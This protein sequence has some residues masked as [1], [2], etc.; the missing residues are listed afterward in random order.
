MEKEFLKTKFKKIFLYF[1]ISFA[2]LFSLRL[3]YGYVEYSDDAVRQTPGQSFNTQNGF[4]LIRKNY[5]SEK[6]FYKTENQSLTL[7]AQT[8]SFDQKY[9]KVG[10]LASSTNEFEKEEKN[11]REL[12]KNFKALIQYEESSG[13][14][15]KRHLNL[16]IGVNPDKFDEMILEIKKIGRLESIQV[17]KTDKTNE[18]SDLN[19]QR[20]SLEKTRTAL[21][22]FKGKG[23]KI[24]ELINLENKILE[25]EE[26]IQKLGVK[27]GE[28]DTENE[29]CTIKFSLSES[30]QAKK[31]WLTIFLHRFKVALEWTI[32]YYLLLMV[33][34]VFAAMGIFLFILILE[35][36]KIFPDLLKKYLE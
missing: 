35:K 22:S 9:E 18:Y 17:N 20:E 5:A 33:L 34:F 21:I 31:S 4:E 10:S 7:P 12:I 36:L 14:E 29:F 13:L 11:T 32:K 26:S 27:L 30:G 28:F 3:I 6:K 24:D 23:G 15:G 19:A 1:L 16:G 8:K 2:G 25:V